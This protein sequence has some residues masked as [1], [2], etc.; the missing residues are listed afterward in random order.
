MG[1][2]ELKFTTPPP[3]SSPPPLVLFTNQCETHHGL[4][5]VPPLILHSSLRDLTQSSGCNGHQYAQNVCIV[6]S[7]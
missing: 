5:L 2:R 4:N 3:Q 6:F 7:V 1:E